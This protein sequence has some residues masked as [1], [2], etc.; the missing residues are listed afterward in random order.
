[1]MKTLIVDDEPFARK[2]LRALLAEAEDFEVVGESGNAI[3]ALADIHRLHPDV[4]FL[5]IQMPRISG[6]EMLAMLDRERMPHIVFVTAYDEYAIRAFEENAFDYLLKPTNRERLA[7]TLVRLRKER[8]AQDFQALGSTI[9]LQHVPCCSVNR[10]YLLR[11]EEIEYATSK[12]SGVYVAAADGEE[13]FTELTLRTLEERTPLLRCHRQYL[14][15]PDQIREIRLV[16]NGLAEIVTRSDKKVPVS[17]RFLRE[18]KERL[19]IS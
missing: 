1:M 14:I 11:L 13:R 2:E 12:L 10:I 18:L 17:R 15:N 3:E 8:G 16:E 9:P 19:G 4:V 5:D 7:K 6:L